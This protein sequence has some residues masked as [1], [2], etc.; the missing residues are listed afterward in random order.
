[1]I[2]V[3]FKMEGMEE[4]QRQ[5][6]ALGERIQKKVLVRSLK[7]CAKP[8][9]DRMKANCP[10][11]KTGTTG[12]RLASR[13]H[14]PGYLRA[15]IGTIVSRG[16]EFPA[17]WV[18]PRFRGNWDPWYEHMVMGGSAAYKDAKANPFVDKTWQEMGAQVESSLTQDL[19]TNIQDEINRL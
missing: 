11:S 16:S 7:K 10:V 8:L 14:P 6:S 1:M 13:N 19:E 12:E 4:L 2:K 3:E 15:T 18:R 9:E 5:F 17:I